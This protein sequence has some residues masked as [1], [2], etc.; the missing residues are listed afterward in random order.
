MTQKAAAALVEKA[1]ADVSRL[2]NDHRVEGFRA[3]LNDLT[4]R[5]A[6]EHRAE[7]LRVI[8]RKITE[9]EG[10]SKRDVLDWVELLRKTLYGGDGVNVTNVNQLSPVTIETDAPLPTPKR[11]HV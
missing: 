3:Y 11:E 5:M 7:L 9:K 4:L 2:V 6:S 8:R 1:E 10:R